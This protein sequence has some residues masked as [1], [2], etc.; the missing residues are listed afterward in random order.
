M[1]RHLYRIVFNKKRGL[2]M[3]VAECATGDGKT[4]GTGTGAR[5]VTFAAFAAFATSA[6]NA[7]SNPAR[8][9]AIWKTQALF[10]DDYGD[11]VTQRHT[12]RVTSDG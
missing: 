5:A 1:N 2:L 4:A 10:D 6:E 8:Q 7:T 9:D 11:G 3:A 12:A